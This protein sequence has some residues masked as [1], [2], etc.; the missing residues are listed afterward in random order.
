MFFFGWFTLRLGDQ[1][2]GESYLRDLWFEIKLQGIFVLLLF[3]RIGISQLLQVMSPKMQPAQDM[4]VEVG[5]GARG[6]ADL[7]PTLA[8]RLDMAQV[9]PRESRHP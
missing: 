8:P 5:E 7:V 2:V 1:R 3:G 6:S 9:S 4:D